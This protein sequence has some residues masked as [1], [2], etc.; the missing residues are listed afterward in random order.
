MPNY[1]LTRKYGF[2][3]FAIGINAFYIVPIIITTYLGFWTD[4]PFTPLNLPIAILG[5]IIMI[6]VTE[7]ISNMNFNLFNNLLDNEIIVGSKN[8]IFERIEKI[9]WHKGVYVLFLVFYV[10]TDISTLNVYLLG[11]IGILNLLVDPIT[12]IV[13]ALLFAEMIWVIGAPLAVMMFFLPRQDLN[14]DIFNSDG[15]MGLGS[16]A[17]YLLLIALM[18]TL[19]GSVVLFWVSDAPTIDYSIALL[20]G[21]I[22]GPIS[23]FILPTIGL[24]RAMKREKYNTLDKLNEKLRKI[25]NNIESARMVDWENPSI[26]NLLLFIRE[27][28]KKNEWP[29]SATGLR[30]LIGS[31][32]IPI[33]IFLI[34]NYT[35]IYGAIFS[36]LVI[37]G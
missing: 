34:T 14:L 7:L 2:W 27:V 29:F 4:M 25:Y 17:N 37:G 10:I 33:G 16:I 11:D 30:N 9:L 24:N 21:V 19:F 26:E 3:P 5:N 32:I 6:V 13:L 22:I 20:L 8:E 23:Y 15:A 28:E 35:A 18:I 36:F 12:N 31:F 1:F